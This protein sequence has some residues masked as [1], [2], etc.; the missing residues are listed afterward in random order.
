MVAYQIRTGK[1]PDREVLTTYDTKLCLNP[2]HLVLAG[3]KSKATLSKRFEAKVLRAG[4]DECWL[5][6]DK[7]IASGYGKLSTGRGS[8][9]ILAHRMAWP[10]A[11]GEIP[12]GLFVMQ[13]CGN[14]QLQ[15]S[16]PLPVAELDR[17]PR[18]IG[19]AVEAWLRSRV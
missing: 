6:T 14:P 11:Y 1:Y 13:R 2:R 18:I 16:P 17:R 5:W 15:H 7:P 10:I 3:E 12:V 4:P 9:P 19:G 8:S